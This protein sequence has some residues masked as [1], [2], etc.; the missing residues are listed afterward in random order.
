MKTQ[1]TDEYQFYTDYYGKIYYYKNRQLYREA[2]PAIVVAKEKDKYSNLDDKDLYKP[3]NFPILKWGDNKSGNSQITQIVV[4][5]M[6]GHS[7]YYLEDV[8]YTESEFKSLMLK[9]ELDG[10]LRENDAVSKKFK[11]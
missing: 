6:M 2:G 1:H 5:L 9:K 7:E 10:Q 8:K 3:I 11:L 4:E